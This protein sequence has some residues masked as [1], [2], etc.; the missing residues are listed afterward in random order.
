MTAEDYQT[1]FSAKSGKNSKVTTPDF[2]V[3]L[4]YEESMVTSRESQAGLKAGLDFVSIL[5]QIFNAS[6]M[7]RTIQNNTRFVCPSNV[8]AL[9]R[10]AEH[11]KFAFVVEYSDI[12]Y[13]WNF[14]QKTMKMIP[15]LSME[16]ADNRH[17]NDYFLQNPAKFTSPKGMDE[18][19]QGVLSRLKCLISSGIFGFWERWDK[20]RFN[21]VQ[22]QPPALKQN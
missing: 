17:A 20:I 18:F 3:Q 12:Q 11:T 10:N 19:R 16:L 13:H 7:V 2:Y 1:S 6:R 8:E 22:S 9:L 14:L 21:L 5:K 4:E 15:G